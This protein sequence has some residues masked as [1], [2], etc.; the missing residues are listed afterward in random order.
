MSNLHFAAWECPDL[1]V[2][3]PAAG[4]MQPTATSI[5]TTTIH[6]PDEYVSL[7][8]SIQFIMTNSPM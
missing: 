3:D 1:Q 5:T 7:L 8:F 2:N 6:K 4:Y